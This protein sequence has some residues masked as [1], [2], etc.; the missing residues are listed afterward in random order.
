MVRVCDVVRRGHHENSLLSGV[1]IG[2]NVSRWHRRRLDLRLRHV[3]PVGNMSLAT[4]GNLLPRDFLDRQPKRWQKSQRKRRVTG[5]LKKMKVKRDKLEERVVKQQVIDDLG[6]KPTAPKR[7]PDRP[8]P[9][10]AD[11]PPS[12]PTSSSTPIGP[13]ARGLWAAHLAPNQPLVVKIPPGVRLCLLRASLFDVAAAPS[14]TARAAVRCRTPAKKEPTT[15]CYLQPALSESCALAAS[16][17]DGDKLCAIAAEGVHAVHIVG[18]YDRPNGV[19]AAASAGHSAAAAPASRASALP[20][21]ATKPSPGPKAPA[22]APPAEPAAPASTALTDLGNG[23]KFVDTKA[24]KGRQAGSGQ[25]LT[26]RYTGACADRRGQ[27]AEFDSNEGK[28]FYFTLG[29]GEVIRGWDVGLL[30]MRQGGTRRLVVPAAFGYGDKGAG[31]IAPGATLVFEVTLLN[32][33]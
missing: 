18:C 26:V 14:S 9:A 1:N 29:E 25:K 13:H 22:A 19:G 24:G 30:G 28:P 2:V 20:A 12:A 17:S 33:V 31:P 8:V 5:M 27:W 32:V 15:L 23:L 11:A 7:G 21:A 16:F 3:G 10:D 4:M 6:A